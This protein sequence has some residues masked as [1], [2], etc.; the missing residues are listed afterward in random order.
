SVAPDRSPYRLSDI[1]GSSDAIRSIKET[2]QMIAPSDLPVLIQ[3][4]SGTGK[5][6]FAH[7]IHQL[8]DRSEQPLIK[9][10]C[11]AIPSDLLEAELFGYSGSSMSTENKGRIHR[12]DGG[13]LFLDDIGSLPLPVQVKL[14]RVL[15][16]GELESL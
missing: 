8:S 4:E 5:E 15:N 11:A 6:L 12:A 13:T 9:V 7:S 1:R 3:G 14:L 16:E 2:I 10:N